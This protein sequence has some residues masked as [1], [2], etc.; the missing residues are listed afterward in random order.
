MFDQFSSCNQS[1]F[2]IAVLVNQPLPV[3]GG[4]NQFIFFDLHKTHHGKVASAHKF[5]VFDEQF[6]EFNEKFVGDHRPA[7]RRSRVDQFRKFLLVSLDAQSNVAPS[8]FSG[9]LTFEAA[10]Y[11]AFVFFGI[12]LS[13]SWVVHGRCS[14]GVSGEQSRSVAAPSGAACERLCQAV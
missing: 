2:D 9:E 5:R 6:L 1:F 12:R 8:T 13:C 3:G 10:V 11:S 4:N 7:F 14:K